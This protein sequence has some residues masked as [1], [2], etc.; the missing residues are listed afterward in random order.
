[1]GQTGTE[2]NHPAA[3]PNHDFLVNDLDYNIWKANFGE[4][5]NHGS[6]GGSLAGGLQGL[7]A[8]PEPAS[9]MLCG[10]GLGDLCSEK[11]TPLIL[12]KGRNSDAC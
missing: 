7:G 9:W 1:M 5:V 2:T 12:L 10:L 8:V 6:G 3:D 11:A 4:P